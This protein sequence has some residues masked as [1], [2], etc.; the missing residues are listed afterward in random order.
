MDEPLTQAHIAYF[1]GLVVAHSTSGRIARRNG[2]SVRRDKRRLVIKH[3]GRVVAVFLFNPAGHASLLLIDA[4]TV[5][6]Q[7]LLEWAHACMPTGSEEQRDA[8]TRAIIAAAP[9]LR[10]A[11]GP[12]DPATAPMVLCEPTDAAEPA[13]L[14]PAPV[15]LLSAQHAGE[16]VH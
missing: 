1:S 11:R 14:V 2:L 4:R 12:G 13:L 15:E 5:W 3:A 7:A 9:A 8:A 6:L 16:T 10:F